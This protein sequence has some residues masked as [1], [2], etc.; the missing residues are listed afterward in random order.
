MRRDRAERI[1]LDLIV[2]SE[3]PRLGWPWT[4]WL[5]CGLDC[6]RRGVPTYRGSGV[7]MDSPVVPVTVDSTKACPVG[8][9]TGVILGVLVRARGRSGPYRHEV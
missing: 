1:E 6:G 8:E 7:H 3:I 4:D 9:F 5:C 2:S